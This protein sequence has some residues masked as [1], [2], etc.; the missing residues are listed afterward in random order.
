[1]SLFVAPV[2]CT[3]PGFD[4]LYVLPLW[5][6][7]SLYRSPVLASQVGAVFA[8][9][10]RDRDTLQLGSVAIPMVDERLMALI[11]FIKVVGFLTQTT[12]SSR[13]T[14]LWVLGLGFTVTKP[15]TLHCDGELCPLNHASMAR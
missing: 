9:N 4:Y 11:V 5:F 13:F 6:C 15:E 10:Q 2:A 3:W 8:F 7:R 12:N 1:M 14:V